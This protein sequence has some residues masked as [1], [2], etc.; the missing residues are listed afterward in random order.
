MKTPTTLD[1]FIPNKADLARKLGLAPNTVY[2][3]VA[4]NALPP[5]RAVDTA[6]ILNIKPERLLPLAQQVSAESKTKPKRFRD[7]DV[8]LA[9]YAHAGADVLESLTPAQ[10]VVKIVHEELIATLGEPSKISLAASPAVM[11]LVGLQGGGKTT[12][13]AKLAR[14]L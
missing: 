1:E 14:V 10:V 5:K 6:M 3:W 11:M 7:L 12:T 2:K 8:L 13:A 4:R 9:A